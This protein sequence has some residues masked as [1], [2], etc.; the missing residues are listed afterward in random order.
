MP[1]KIIFDLTQ[2]EMK[3]NIYR[4]T[5]RTEKRQFRQEE[6]GYGQIRSQEVNVGPARR[7][8]R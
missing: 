6:M 1:P 4:R 8:S 3:T 7:P 2:K 5:H